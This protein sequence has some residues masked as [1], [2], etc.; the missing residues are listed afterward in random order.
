MVDKNAANERLVYEK[1][2]AN[3]YVINY[4]FRQKH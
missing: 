4:T 2:K 3:Y 1:V